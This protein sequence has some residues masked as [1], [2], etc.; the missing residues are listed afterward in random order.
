MSWVQRTVVVFSVSGDRGDSRA[1]DLATRM[2]LGEACVRDMAAAGAHVIV[3]DPDREAVGRIVESVRGDGGTISGVVAD[4]GDPDAL[5]LA[6]EEVA[7]AH[8]R[9][10][11]LVT[12]HS[13]IELSSIEASTPETWWRVVAFDLLGPVFA[14]K[15]FLP[16][17]KRGDHP[18]I[19]HVGSI[20]GTLG[21]PQVPSYSAAKGGLVPLTHVMAEEFGRYGIR[22]NCV[23]RAVTVE[24]GSDE[25][26]MFAAL[27]EQTP[28]ARAGRAQEVAATIRFLASP[29]AS[30]V[31]GVVLP[32]DGGRSGVTPGT[33]PM[34]DKE[35]DAV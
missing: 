18:A 3:V 20:D 31:S 33:R 7:A 17:L 27:I 16:L 26:P 29:D 25:H 22:V 9:V 34:R 35:A 6:A 28:L 14:V 4:S 32:V 11:V 10:D 21:N 8:D 30:Y 2:H 12:C 23:A 15:A 24:P 1:R 19:V 13:D 5:A